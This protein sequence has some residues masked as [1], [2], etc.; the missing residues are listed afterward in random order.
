MDPSAVPLVLFPTPPP[1]K[2]STCQLVFSLLG[3]Y[4]GP[5]ILQISLS[6]L[7]TCPLFSPSHFVKSIKMIGNK[8]ARKGKVKWRRKKKSEKWRTTNKN[9]KRSKQILKLFQTCHKHFWKWT[10]LAKILNHTRR[11]FFCFKKMLFKSFWSAL[12][13]P[14]IHANGLHDSTYCPLWTPFIFKL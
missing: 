1:L 5:M 13:R 3:S 4:L 8:K 9:Y 12:F 10:V 7:F 11:L 2:N 6:R 14:L